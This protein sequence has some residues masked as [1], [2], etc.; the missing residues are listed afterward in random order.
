MR[1]RVVRTCSLARGEVREDPMGR[2]PMAAAAAAAVLFAVVV[3]ASA[4]TGGVMS[5]LGGFGFQRAKVPAARAGLTA[6][7]GKKAEKE[8]KLSFPK[9]E[10]ILASEVRLLEEAVDD[11]AVKGTI[12][13]KVNIVIP[14]GEALRRARDKGFDLIMVQGNADPPNVK[15]ASYTKYVYSE[16]KRLKER[17]RDRRQ[18]KTKEVKLTYTIGDH[19]LQTKVRNVEKWMGTPRQQ[20][21]VIVMMKGRAKMFEKQARTII[22]RVREEVCTFA[23]AAGN[24]DDPV[25]KDGRGDLNMLLIAGMDQQLVKEL[26]S[27]ASKEDLEAMQR[28]LGDGGEEDDVEEDTEE[29]PDPDDPIAQE[30]AEIE[31]E[32]AE[33]RAELLDCGVRPN[34]V[35]REPEMKE[36]NQK[37]QQ[38]KQKVV[39]SAFGAG[40]LGP[41]QRPT[42][43]ALALGVAAGV[44]AGAFAAA[45][46]RASPLR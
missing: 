40:V 37:L 42:A 13:E 29:G 23:R 2:H 3:T 31:K 44:V 27:R 35:N 33:M 34:E 11:P 38:L 14:T 10:E 16:T 15:I 26:R 46:R 8:D 45:R 12:M 30:I 39:A 25:T 5:F 7:Y 22:Q 28:S 4:G 19:D 9:N 6:R 17:D 43:S 36:L 32:M 41:Q 18:P 21:K 20:V 1:R 24:Y